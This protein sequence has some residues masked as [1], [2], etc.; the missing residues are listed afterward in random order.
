MITDTPRCDSW[1]GFAAL[2]ADEKRLRHFF[3][4]RVPPPSI[5][6]LLTFPEAIG[7]IS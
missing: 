6:L 4:L 5:F 2:D 1:R 7:H 3:G